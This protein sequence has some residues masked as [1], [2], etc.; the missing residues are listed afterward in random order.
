MTDKI[1]E[2][3]INE[4]AKEM[5]V[6]PKIVL[7][8]YKHFLDYIYKMMTKVKLKHM[9]KEYIRQHAVNINIP[10]FGRILNK[11][12]KTIKKRKDKSN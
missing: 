1:L 7:A 8:V 9:S 5:G 6:R 3:I 12:G 4:V 2:K 10:G 11:Y